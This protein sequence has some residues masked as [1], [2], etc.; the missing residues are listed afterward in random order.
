[1]AELEEKYPGL[2]CFL[3]THDELSF[4]VPEDNWEQWDH[5]IIEVMEHLPTQ[6]YFGWTPKVPLIAEG[7]VGF[8]MSEMFEP[9]D[10]GKFNAYKASGCADYQE[11]MASDAT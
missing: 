4:Y 7:S 5:D 8:V 6:K 2:W 1:M 9:S 11:F 3:M 10:Y